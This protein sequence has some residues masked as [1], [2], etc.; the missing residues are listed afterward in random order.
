[1][2]KIMFAVAVFLVLFSS[3][4]VNAPLS[5]A[6]S[7]VIP[8]MQRPVAEKSPFSAENAGVVARVYVSAKG[9]FS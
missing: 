8:E 6:D 1:M 3:V 2:N 4:V 9:Q 5:S 7:I